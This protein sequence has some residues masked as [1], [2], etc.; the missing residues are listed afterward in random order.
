[1][2][3]ID[4]VYHLVHSMDGERSFAERDVRAELLV[5]ADE[6][7]GLAKLANRFDAYPRVAAF[8]HEVLGR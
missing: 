6:G 7:H 4:A 1:M 5:Y 2:T 3:G 8:L